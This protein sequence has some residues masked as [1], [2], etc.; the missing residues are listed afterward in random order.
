MGGSG[1]ACACW[2]ALTRWKTSSSCRESRWRSVGEGGR[3]SLCQAH[4]SHSVQVRGRG[5]CA[6]HNTVP[7]FQVAHSCESLH[8]T[9]RCGFSHSKAV[10]TMPPSLRCRRLARSSRADAGDDSLDSHSDVPR[11]RAGRWLLSTCRLL[12]ASTVTEAQADAQSG[13]LSLSARSSR[14]HRS[15]HGRRVTTLLL[16]SPPAFESFPSSHSSLRPP[17]STYPSTTSP[18][19]SFL[20]SLRGRC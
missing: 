12:V 9:R 4:T 20:S 10:A 2:K 17:P 19:P 1:D 16:P 14:L 8:T 11:Y 7:W 6:I 3:V 18:Y 5:I 15:R 13:V